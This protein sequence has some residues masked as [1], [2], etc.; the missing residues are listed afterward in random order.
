MASR[1][2]RIPPDVDLRDLSACGPLLTRRAREYFGEVASF[3]LRQAR[4]KGPV[5]IRFA[6]ASA[7]RELVVAVHAITQ[8]M[9]RTYGDHQDATEHGAYGVALLLA[10]TEMRMQFAGRCYKGPGFDF[11]L[12]PPG[13]LSVDANDIFA[14]N[15][16]LEATGILRGGER[17]ISDRFR[18][19]RKQVAVA[20][21]SRRILIA[22][23][24]FSS[25]AAIFELRQ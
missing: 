18:I 10:A 3:C 25:A 12:A 2:P 21:R 8:A 1:K 9:R 24:E 16:G 17:E 23:V 6:A 11:L 20:A 22:V 15:W 7:D 13:Q 14:D 4:P 5:T 19:K